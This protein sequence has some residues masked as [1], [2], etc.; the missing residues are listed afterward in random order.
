M[1]NKIAATMTAE[2]FH[3]HITKGM[4]LSITGAAPY[5]GLSP[6][7]CQ[8]IDADESPVPEP[9]AKLLRVIKR[10]KVPIDE[11]LSE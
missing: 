6:R 5:L 9:V 7:Q 2:Q 8:R 1:A 11:L 3:D 10:H 4:G